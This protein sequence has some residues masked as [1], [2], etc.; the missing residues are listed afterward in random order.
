MTANVRGRRE[1][2]S[3]GHRPRTLRPQL[4]RDFVRRT[5]HMRRAG[6]LVG[7]TLT[8]V[9]CSPSRSDANFDRATRT[10]AIRSTAVTATTPAWLP[11][12]WAFPGS[13]VPGFCIALV[14]DSTG[15]F[16]G[17]LSRLSPFRWQ[18]RSRGDTLHLRQRIP[19]SGWDP[20]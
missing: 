16:E 2:P 17:G 6:T 4:R 14:D 10:E 7:F 13:D 1:A 18:Y 19:G 11:R 15:R 9:A 8:L 20:V 3:E 5:P 12:V